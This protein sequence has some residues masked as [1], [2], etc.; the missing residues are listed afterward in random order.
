MKTFR[1]IEKQAQLL[2]LPM[3]DLFVLLL[4]MSLL[5]VLGIVLNLMI[6]LS[7]YYFWTVILATIFAYFLLRKVNRQRHP[8]LLFSYLSYRFRQP[9]YL[10]VWGT[11]NGRRRTEFNKRR[12]HEDRRKSLV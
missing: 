11:E 1:S 4:L 6:P 3:N 9:K 2:G 7:K 8:T 10:S 5:I 12:Q